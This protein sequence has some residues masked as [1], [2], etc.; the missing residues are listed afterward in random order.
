MATRQREATL[1]GEMRECGVENQFMQREI[2]KHVALI[3]KHLREGYHGMY[4]ES[5]GTF[6][7]PFL[8]PG[9]EAY[10]DVLWNW[11]YLVLNMI[12]WLE[13]QETITE[14]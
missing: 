10:A 11:N 14:F 9:S 7:H 4:R 6:E 12:A 3:R 2:A 5:G 8:T 13:G 1:A